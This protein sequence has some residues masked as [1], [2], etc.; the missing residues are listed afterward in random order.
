M[1]PWAE[2]F[3]YVGV[4]IVLLASGFGL[5]IPEDLPLITGGYLAGTGRADPTIMVIVAFL[6]VMGGDSIVYA[7]GRLYGFQLTRIRFVRMFLSKKRVERAEQLFHKHGGKT[8]FVAR[9][10]PGL[11]AATFFIAGTFRISYWKFLFFDGTA[12]LISVPLIVLLAWF[13]ADQIDQVRHWSRTAQFLLGMVVLS[14]VLCYF[15]VKLYRG[16]RRRRALES[17]K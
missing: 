6:S 2:E 4:A 13:F 15:A 10:L 16:Y 3:A 12:A 17:R 7:L 9:F 5:P 14:A 8:L 1:E 11:R